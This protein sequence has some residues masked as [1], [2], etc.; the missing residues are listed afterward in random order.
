MA[1]TRA[2]QQLFAELQDRYGRAVAE[3]FFRAV[4]DL[5]AGVELQRVT[6]AIENGDVDA[7]LEALHIDPAAYADVSEA[8]RQSY[9][10]GG[11]ATAQQLPRRRPDGTA[12]VVRFNGANPEAERWLSTSSAALV[13]RITADQRE[14]VRQRLSA[15][16][17]NGQN[18]RVV[19]LDIVGRINRATGK[20][21]GGILG[22]SAVQ[23]EYVATARDE[24]TSDDPAILG[25]FLTR[26]RRDRRFDRSI[27][28]AI[29]EG[30]ALQPEIAR[31]AAAGYERRLLQLRGEMI[32]KVEVFNALAEAKDRAYWQA[33]D[34]GKLSAE[35][36]RIR[37]R[38]LSNEHPRLDHVA[39]NGR[40]IKLGGRFVLPDGT[41]MRFP[42]DPDGSV[43]HNAGCHCQGDYRV[44]WLATAV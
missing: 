25:H 31:K 10:E 14:A 19:A 44:D 36:V 34:E 16:M 38:H 8:V 20:R 1:T 2:Q 13:T 17:Q 40:T 11:R 29:R 22:L 15:G 21:E 7:A 18:P 33:V 41:S 39:M 32:G 12:M 43:K 26:A 27:T 28:K 23:A 9:L 24:L 5:R 35:M 37:W 30:Q 6:V 42:H 3:A 4:E